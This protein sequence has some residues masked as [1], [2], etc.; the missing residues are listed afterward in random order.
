[1]TYVRLTISNTHSFQR[2]IKGSRGNS[3]I[4][5]HLIFHNKA[6]AGQSKTI[7]FSHKMT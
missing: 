1:M 7:T 2:F 3:S 4:Y 6:I 5:S